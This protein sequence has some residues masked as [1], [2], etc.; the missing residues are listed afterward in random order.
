MLVLTRSS[1]RRLTC[2]GLVAC[3]LVAAPA[4]ADQQAPVSELPGFE[5]E[6]LPQFVGISFDDN[7]SVNNILWTNELFQALVNPAGQGISNNYDGTPV[8]VTFFSNSTYLET[9]GVP[10]AW[11]ESLDA[12]HEIGNHTE[13][14]PRGRDD[15]GLD[16]AGWNA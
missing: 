1:T 13:N 9:D 8:R 15:G 12:G 7:F 2:L 10:E 6:E 4:Y 14:H 3:A 5:P 16:L 11:K